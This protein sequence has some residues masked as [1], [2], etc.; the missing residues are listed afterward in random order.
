MV[1]VY[2]AFLTIPLSIF[3]YLIGV[4]VVTLVTFVVGFLFKLTIAKNFAGNI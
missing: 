4:A 1:E 3:C 2:T